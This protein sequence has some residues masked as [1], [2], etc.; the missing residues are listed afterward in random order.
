M[1]N[2][3]V[4]CGGGGVQS[5]Q[6]S[7][8]EKVTKSDLFNLVYPVG[9][10]YMSMN[11]TSPAALF[12]GT[13]EQI[14]DT[15]LLGSGSYIIGTTGGE[16]EHQLTENELPY[17]EGHFTWHGEEHGTHIYHIDGHC[18]GY[19]IDNMYQ[20]T[21]QSTGAESYGGTGFAFGGN[22]SHNNMPPYLVVNIWKRTA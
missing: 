13:W 22:W 6:K 15:F 7:L 4:D 2:C 9:S 18:T 10:I 20:T 19:R 14:R 5:L 3:N 12:G 1:A 21:A 8:T 17:I 11:N 16:K